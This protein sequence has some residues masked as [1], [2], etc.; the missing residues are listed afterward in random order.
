MPSGRFVGTD[1]LQINSVNLIDDITNS[2]E[3]CFITENGKAR[4]VLMDIHRYNALMDL[5]EEA[6]SPKT[7]HPGEETRKHI[8]VRGILQRS[9]STRFFRKKK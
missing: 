6:E 8:S 7:A 3:T 5:I 9:T 2:G 4:A 1:E